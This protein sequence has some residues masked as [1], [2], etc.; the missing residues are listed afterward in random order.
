MNLAATRV[1]ELLSSH[2]AALDSQAEGRINR[3]EQEVAQLRRRSAELIRLADM[4]DP[5]CF[6]KV[7]N[8]RGV[9]T[10]EKDGGSNG[11]LCSSE[12]PH[13]GA[14]GSK[15]GSRRVGAATGGRG[16]RRPLHHPTASGVGEGA[17]RR[18][19]GEDRRHPSVFSFSIS[20]SPSVEQILVRHAG[21]RNVYS[22]SSSLLS[23]PRTAHRGRKR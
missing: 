4:R 22:E 12:L 11:V 5:V 14:A 16:R 17:V 2:Q 10:V 8:I 6:L 19:P 23:E 7:T 9:E 15:R 3:L 21:R 20:D 13:Y 18:Q 1:N